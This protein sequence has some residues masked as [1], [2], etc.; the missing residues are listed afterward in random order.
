MSFIQG[1]NASEF[2]WGTDA[3]DTIYAGDGSDILVGGRGGDTLIG[4]SGTDTANYMTSF[5]AVDVDLLRS[6]AQ[7]GGDA[8]GDTLFSIE[9]LTGSY[10]NDIL[11]GSDQSNG[12]LG[13]AGDDSLFGRG[14]ND[15]IAGGNGH[16]MI[17]GDGGADRMSGGSGP[18]SFYLDRMNDSGVGAG[19]RDVI[20]DFSHADGDKINLHIIDAKTEVA[21]EQA[22]KFV[23]SGAF[24]GPGEVH[25]SFE[26]DHTVVTAV[27]EHETTEIQL[28]GHVDLTAKDFVL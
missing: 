8:E 17:S 11:R 14:G 27:T 16:D 22:F 18:D 9:S 23:G 7:H 26:G 13:G 25:T 1:S 2:I 28:A 4:A 24:T 5:N 21:G 20:D 15:R 19:N 3:A 12:L 6:G 10:N